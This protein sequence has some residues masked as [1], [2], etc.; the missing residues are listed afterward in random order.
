MNQEQ[1]EEWVRQQGGQGRVQYTTA[2]REIDDP[3]ADLNTAKAAGVRYNPMLPAGAKITINEEKW[4]AVDANGKATGA[5]LH[6]QRKPDGTLAVLDQSG[7]NPAARSGSDASTEPPKTEDRGGRHYVWQPNAPGT[8]GGGQWVDAGPAPLSPAEQAAAGASDTRPLEGY[9]GWNVR[10]VKV[11][12]DTRTVYVNPQGQEA[13]DPRPAANR[14]QSVE[15]PAPGRPGWLIRKTTDPQTG[16]TTTVYVD[17]SG[18]E[19]SGTPADVPKPEKAPDGSYGYWD[20]SGPQPKWV[21]IEG[22]PQAQRTP[23]QVD[24]QWGVW[25]PGEGGIPS[26]HPIKTVTPADIPVLQTKYGEIAQGLGQLAAD[27]NGRVARGEM[28]PQQRSE[29]FQAAHQQADVQVSEINGILSNSRAAWA[30]QIEQRGQTLSETASRRGYAGDVLGRAI[31]YGSELGRSAGPGH[32]KEITGGMLA[33]MEMGQRLATG[34]GGLRDSPEIQMPAALQQAQGIGLPG[35]GAPGGSVSGPPGITS[36][37]PGALP[38]GISDTTDRGGVPRV[39]TPASATNAP[40]ALVGA[41]GSGFGLGSNISLPGGAPAPGGPSPIQTLPGGAP[42]TPPPIGTLPGGAPGAP[43]PI[44]TLP[45]GAPHP[46]PET[47]NWDPGPGRGVPETGNWDV[48]PS[49][50]VPETAPF[51]GGMQQQLLAALGF[52]GSPVAAGGQGLWD[53][54]QEMASM[55]GDGSDPEW[56]AAVQAAARDFKRPAVGSGVESGY[57]RFG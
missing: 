14:P 45:G 57:R 2:A 12:P 43:L 3:A 50:G 13:Q 38:G 22:G 32:G 24:G 54:D 55:V 5:V 27:L 11:G 47:G 29:A 8:G 44:Q 46:V 49:R 7:A 28:T 25:T 36:G 15:E 26:F 53:P 21:P 35:Y 16:N 10:T 18:R 9:P 17:P 31:T 52:G 33:M 30:Q 48:G 4:T 19:V 23:V 40:S 34:M 51:V 6:V 37:P 1:F 39:M 41:P 42:G 20:T 56:A